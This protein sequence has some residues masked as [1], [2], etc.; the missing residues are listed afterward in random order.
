MRMS[1]AQE[2]HDSWKPSSVLIA[3]SNVYLPPTLMVTHLLSSI[4]GLTIRLY[5]TYRYANI[6]LLP[7]NLDG[8]SRYLATLMKI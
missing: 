2:S 6:S 5:A 4:H 3:A 1:G 7:G 8:R